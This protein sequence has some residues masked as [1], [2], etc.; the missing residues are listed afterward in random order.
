MLLLLPLEVPASL[1]GSA[2]V[3]VAE[4]DPGVADAAPKVPETALDSTISGN[5]GTGNTSM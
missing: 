2:D 5:F 1:E 4:T 3:R